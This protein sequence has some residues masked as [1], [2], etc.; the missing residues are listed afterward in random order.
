[1]HTIFQLNRDH[2]RP[3]GAHCKVNIVFR[4]VMGSSPPMR[5][6]S[7]VCI[8]FF[9]LTGIIP[10]HAGHMLQLWQVLSPVGIIPAHAGHI[11]IPA[12]SPFVYGDHPRP[13]GAHAKSEQRQSTNPGSSPPMRGTLLSPARKLKEVGIIPAHAG[14]ILCVH[15]IF[16]TNRDHP[17]PCGAHGQFLLR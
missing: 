10:A 13:C 1:M 5:G 7:Y 4:T 16:Q 17:R 8:R 14:H 11:A 15:T 2:P 12:I 3:C 9:S 6:T